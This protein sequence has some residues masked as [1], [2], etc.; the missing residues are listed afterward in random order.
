MF[1]F[2]QWLRPY[3]LIMPEQWNNNMAA[4]RGLRNE[5]DCMKGENTV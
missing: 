5:L 3:L 4:T 2:R 1:F